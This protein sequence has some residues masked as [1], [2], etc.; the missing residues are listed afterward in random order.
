MA[1]FYL[2]PPRELLERAVG[3]LLGKLLPGLPLPAD[4]W[5]A[6]ARDVAAAAGWSDV[7]LIPRDELPDG[8]PAEALAAGYGADPADRVVEV[9]LARPPRVWQVPTAVSGAAAAR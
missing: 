1:T 4:T 5:D 6:L 8:D 9:S 7:Y 3:E 2:L